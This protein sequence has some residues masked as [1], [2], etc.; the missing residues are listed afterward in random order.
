MEETEWELWIPL[1]PLYLDHDIYD[2]IAMFCDL[3]RRMLEQYAPEDI[4]WLGFSAETD[5]ILSTDRYRV[6]QGQ[7]LP[8][9]GL[10]I[11]ISDC[12]LTISEASYARMKEMRS[13]IL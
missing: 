5:M 13:G 7:S 12:N 3:H 8:M 4:A 2:E 11:P 6:Q 1:Y 10:M 9:P